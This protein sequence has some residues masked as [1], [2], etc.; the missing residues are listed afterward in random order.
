MGPPCATSTLTLQVILKAATSLPGVASPITE[1]RTRR[2]NLQP[3]TRSPFFGY[4]ASFM[5]T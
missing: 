5:A 3:D 2:L 1:M 4:T